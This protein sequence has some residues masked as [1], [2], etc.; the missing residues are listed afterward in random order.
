MHEEEKSSQW[1][2]GGGSPPFLLKSVYVG[3]E[4]DFISPAAMLGVFLFLGR[5]S[6]TL[7]PPPFALRPSSP[8]LRGRMEELLQGTPPS[9]ARCGSGG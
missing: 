1:M 4:D 9:S 8:R 3:V 6:F 7:S 5:F 2:F